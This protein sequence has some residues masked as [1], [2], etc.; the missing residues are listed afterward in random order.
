[1]ESAS[2]S[3]T[4]ANMKSEQKKG[5]SLSGQQKNIA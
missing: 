5:L 1:M 2:I 3:H 4:F